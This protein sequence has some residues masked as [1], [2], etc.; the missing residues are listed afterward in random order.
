MNVFDQYIYENFVL[1]IEYIVVYVHLFTICMCIYSVGVLVN[2]KIRVLC[3]QPYIN[4]WVTKT[5]IIQTSTCQFLW[6]REK[7]V[8]K[9]L[10]TAFLYNHYLKQLYLY[11]CEPDFLYQLF[12]H[13]QVASALKNENQKRKI[14][15]IKH[16][17]VHK[18]AR[19]ER[20]IITGTH[21]G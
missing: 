14:T 18:S 12:L 3:S 17:F 6:I 11:V 7:K 9:A 1:I 15:R 8:G 19:F 2:V 20:R 5:A 21:L 16:S 4:Q 13:R 10:D